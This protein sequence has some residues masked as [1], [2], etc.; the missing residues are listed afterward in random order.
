MEHR[1]KIRYYPKEKAFHVVEQRNLRRGYKTIIQKDSV[2]DTRK[3][4]NP[5]FAKTFDALWDLDVKSSVENRLI[6]FI[7][8][9][10]R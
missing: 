2:I 1:F 8:T 3:S 4:E 5:G 10:F 9:R 6:E 7:F